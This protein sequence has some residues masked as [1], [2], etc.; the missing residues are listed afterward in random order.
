MNYLYILDI[1]PLSVTSFANNFFHSVG[2]LFIEKMVFIFSFA[3]Q[4]LVSL[5]R[6]HLLIF[7]FI[8]L[9]LGDRPK[10]TFVQFTSDNFLPVFSSRSFMVP[11]LMFK[12]LGHFES[13]PVY[14]ETSLIFVQLS[15]FPNTT[16]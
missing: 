1:K 12:S 14:D 13:I 5:I 7:V 15:N 16:Y 6:F 2:F 9:A 3:V 11:C 10:K 8:S 4:K